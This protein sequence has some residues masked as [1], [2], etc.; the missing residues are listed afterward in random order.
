M[1]LVLFDIDGTLVDTGGAGRRAI[2]AAARQ[3]YN[4]PD[5]FD[6]VAFDGATDRAICR[7]ALRHLD[8]SFDETEID[9][10]LDTYLAFLGDEVE[11]SARY[12]IYPGVE[13]VAA[14]MESHGVL[15]GLGTGNVEPGAR[16]KLERGNLNRFFSFGGFGDDAEDR[17]TLIRMGLRRGEQ[18]LG[19]RAKEAWVIGDTPKDHSAARAAGAKVVLVATG[20]YSMAEL[21]ACGPDLCVETLEDKRVLSLLWQTVD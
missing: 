15:L 5:L 10:L 6:D 7:A 13:Q 1:D 4:R 17:G 3:L 18:I 11:R 16:V 20:R 2:E 21:S 9:R 14:A 12:L 19:R 8:R